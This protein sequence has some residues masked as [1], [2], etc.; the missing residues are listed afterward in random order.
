MHIDI[1]LSRYI[2]KAMCL[3]ILKQPINC[4]KL[5]SKK[6]EAN[7]HIF[8]IKLFLGVDCRANSFVSCDTWRQGLPLYRG[9]TIF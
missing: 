6:E 5:G 3:K 7:T 4:N 8:L 2:V 9:K 1:Q